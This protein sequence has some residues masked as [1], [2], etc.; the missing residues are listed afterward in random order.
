[1]HEKNCFITL[2]YDNDHIPHGGT[3]NKEELQKFF[4]RLRKR[5]FQFRY[6]ACGEY[7]EQGL[8]PHYHAVLFG[9][10]FAHDRKKHSKNAQGDII[11]SSSTL[12]EVWGSGQCRIGAFNYSTAAYVA[13][14][15]MKK[16]NGKNAIDAEQ[17]ERFDVHGEIFSVLPEF[18]LMSRRPGIGTEWYEKFGSDAFPSD[19]LIHQGKKHPV[20]RYYFD[21]LKKDNPQLAE[22][23]RIK[24]AV[25]RSISEEREERLPSDALYDKFVNKSSQLSKLSR[26]L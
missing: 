8:R 5:G 13:R 9:V 21:K 16:Q 6:Y 10:D 11:Y 7:G 4:K 1:M 22:T 3:L 18:A 17:Y 23:I 25:A 15:C 26:S 12:D 14:Y 24:R 19:F 20:P 2:T